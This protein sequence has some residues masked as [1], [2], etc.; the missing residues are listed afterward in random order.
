MQIQ[1]V[2]DSLTRRCIALGLKAETFEEECAVG[3]LYCVFNM[4]GTK[5]TIETMDGNSTEININQKEEL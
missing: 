3:F 1:A 5:I 4:P 2:G